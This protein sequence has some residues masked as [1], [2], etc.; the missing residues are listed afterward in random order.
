MYKIYINDIPLI[1]CHHS[2]AKN[3]ASSLVPRYNGKPATLFNYIDLLEKTHRFDAVFLSY[4]DVNQL[5][6]DFKGLYK[7]IEA[8]GGLVL[9]KESKML[10]IL[11]RGFWDLPKGKIENNE[12]IE[13]AA[14]REVNE[15]T[16]LINLGITGNA[17][18]GYHT[19]KLNGKRVLK[20]THWF[21]MITEDTQLFLQAEEDIEDAIWADPLL[22]IGEKKNMYS[23]LKNLI[24]E[25]YQNLV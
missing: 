19:Y 8:A 16:G 18:M 9:N 4:H 11:R 25:F 10:F 6:T 2:D 12:T 5:F 15:E 21:P 24:L 1:L 20:P 3:A 7:I 14:L 22:F 13:Q 17:I 23:N